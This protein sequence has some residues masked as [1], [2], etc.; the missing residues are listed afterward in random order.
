MAVN[1]GRAAAALDHRLVIAGDEARFFAGA[2]ADGTDGTRP[3]DVVV[4][5]DTF[6][7]H[8][9]PDNARAALSVLARAGLRAGVTGTA[10]C[11][12]LTWVSTGQLDTARRELTRTVRALE[13][14]AAAGGAGCR[15]SCSVSCSSPV[16]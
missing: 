14:H 5:A 15:W 2:G 8:F 9:T 10:V 11:C 6:T 13:P 7:D 12:G 3:L 4:W 1:L 16:A